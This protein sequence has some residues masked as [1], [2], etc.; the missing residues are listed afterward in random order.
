[1]K[2][3]LTNFLTAMGIAAVGLILPAGAQAQSHCIPSCV[4]DD[5]EF[6]VITD[7]TGLTTL[8]DENLNFALR[9]P[10][11]TASF[12]LGVFDGKE[13]NKGRVVLAPV[14]STVGSVG[15]FFFC[16][17]ISSMCFVR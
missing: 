8:T 15:C 2:A 7:G 9:V 5:G 4:V 1:M 14:V 3:R 11:G 10:A 17:R 12:Q 16:S 6:L 13:A